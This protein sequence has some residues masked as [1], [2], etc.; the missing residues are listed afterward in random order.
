MKK[1]VKNQKCLNDQ[2]VDYLLN[3]NLETITRINF[4]E[5]R[6][7]KMWNSDNC[8]DERMNEKSNQWGNELKEQWGK[9]SLIMKLFKDFN[10]DE[11]RNRSMIKESKIGGDCFYF[12]ENYDV[13]IEDRNLYKNKFYLPENKLSYENFQKEFELLESIK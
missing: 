8:D 4:I 5:K 7:E 13:K 1:S 2:L 10:L 11:G 6:F 3:E 12:L 9:L